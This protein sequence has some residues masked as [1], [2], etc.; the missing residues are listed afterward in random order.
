[1]ISTKTPHR[2][3]AAQPKTPCAIA[4]SNMQSCT[5]QVVLLQLH[6]PNA[7]PLACITDI[8]CLQPSTRVSSL[9]RQPS[10]TLSA[11]LHII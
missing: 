6:D 1:M 4:L 9:D 8:R 5:A 2:A 3:T 7:A 10:H 11:L